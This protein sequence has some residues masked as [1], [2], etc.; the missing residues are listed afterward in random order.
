MNYRGSSR[1]LS[2]NAQSALLGAIEIYNKPGFQYR[3]ECFVIL[4]LNAWELL[5]KAIVS[6][7]G[8]SIY[9]P[10]KRK[11][12]S[13]R[14]VSVT[15]ALARAERLFPKSIQ[16]L[17]IQHNL[18]L[19]STYRD[20]AIHFYNEPG[21]GLLVYSLAQT[22]ILNFRDLLLATFGSNLAKHISWSLMP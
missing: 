8:G 5:L 18:S 21:F 3:D 7:N 13:Y 6:K 4:L 10:K 9:Y 20:N 19:L 12:P 11:D 14:T 15:D 1:H 2:R 22:S 17:P 16:I